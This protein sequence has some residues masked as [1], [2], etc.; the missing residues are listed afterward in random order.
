MHFWQGYKTLLVASQAVIEAN[1]AEGSH[2]DARQGDPN[3]RDP[4]Q[5][6]KA[7]RGKEGVHKG[8]GLLLQKGNHH[9]QER[10][11]G[12]ARADEDE[13]GPPDLVPPVP[14][15]A[16]DH[17]EGS[18]AATLVPLVSLYSRPHVHLAALALRERV[19]QSVALL[20]LLHALRDRELVHLK[21]HKNGI[22]R[23]VSLEAKW[24]HRFQ[25]VSR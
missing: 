24:K 21:Q 7:I 4:P 14:V 1:D 13:N 8:A 10:E 11:V 16:T 22:G 2:D 5:N 12:E 6:V 19:P 15:V 9:D 20:R 3:D 25:G 23:L 17:S 18:L